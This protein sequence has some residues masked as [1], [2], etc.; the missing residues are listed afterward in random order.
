MSNKDISN[1]IQTLINQFNIKN[2]DNVISKGKII[3]KKY[4]EYVVLYNLIGSSLQSLGEYEE[5]SNYFKKGLQLDSNN[6][7]L[8]NNLA[9]SYKNL[10]HYKEAQN[11]YLKIIDINNKYINAYVNL[12]NLKRDLNQ[13]D[14]SIK[15]YEKA[16]SISNNYPIVY[17]S[18]ALAHQGIGNFEKAIEYSKKTLN[19]NPNFT[20]ADHLISQSAKYTEKNPHYENLKKKISEINPKSFEMVD[21]CFSL[22]KAEEDL[23]NIDKASNYMI[24]G[25]KLKKELIQFNIINDLNLIKNVKNKFK[26]INIEIKDNKKNNKII[27]I[28]GMPRSGTSLVEQIISSHS[29]VFGCGELPILSKIVKDNFIINEN[30]I[31]DNLK[32]VCDDEIFLEKLNLDYFS[33]LK[34]FEIEEEYITD[35]APLNFRWIGFIKLILPGAKIIHC[36][37]DPKNNCL[38][39]FKNLFEG[40]LNFSYDQEDLVKYYRQYVDLMEFWQSKYKN[41]I[42]DIKYENLVSNNE[43]EIKKIIKFCGLD[44]EKNCLSFYKNKTPIKTMSTAQ[45]RQP[46]YR[47]SLN[48]FEKYKGYLKI[49]EN[50]E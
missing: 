11:L 3:L 23:K 13:F 48:S 50:M 49:I 14:E 36:Q 28:L 12:G 20:Q 41:S 32:N 26:N 42:L 47:T 35:K 21:L 9:M 17:Y 4:P 30:D 2:F 33:F 39:I 6:L 38:S 27:F 46:I 37:R 29:K 10:L 8:M 5:A 24:R 19:L 31:S 34:N 25:N 22:S 7:A 43:E 1:Q 18:L 44:F 16:L 40:G 15:L 45:A